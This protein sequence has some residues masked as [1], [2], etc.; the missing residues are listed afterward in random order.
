VGSF[1]RQ[2][3]PAA[4]K[5][6]ALDE[7]K[8]IGALEGIEEAPRELT[9]FEL[10]SELEPRD[11]HGIDKLAIEEQERAAEGGSSRRTA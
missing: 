7:S 1:E 11:M 10:V 8:V 4:R 3:F 2:V 6:N 5:L 9:A